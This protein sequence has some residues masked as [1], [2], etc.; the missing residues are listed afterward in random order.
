MSD[1]P[2]ILLRAEEKPLEHRSF[3]PAVIK[4]LVDAGYPISVERSS[5]DPNFKRIFEDSEYEAAGASLIPA[6]SWPEAPAGTLI[7]GLKEIPEEDFPL[8]NDHISFA[9]C[10]K[11]QGGWEKVLSRFPRGGSVLYDLEFLVDS[12]GRRVSAFGFHAGFTGAALG[13]KTLQWQLAHPGEKLPSVGTFTDGRGYYLN[14]EELVNQIREDLASAEK[15]LGRKPTAMV[16][17]ALGRCGRGAVDLFL[18]AGIPEENIT[19]WDIQET[20][21]REGPYE[22]IAQHDIFLN[23]IYLSKPIPPFVNDELLSQPGRKLGVV[24]DVSCDTTNPHNPIPIYSINTTFDDPTVPV[25]VKD[26]QNTSPLSVIS[27][28]H[29]PSMLPRE[30]S[31]AFSEGLKESLLTLN[32]R[33]TSRVWADAEKLFNEKVALLPEE[34]RTKE[35]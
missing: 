20:Q 31:E 9:H 34:L 5:T 11:N 21:A 7:L 25:T 27:I 4:T 26:D 3:S 24:I 30:A 18:K 22:E 2:A 8:K 15:A 32:E 19:R 12:E 35:V 10:Y 6:G 14:E 1:Y 29:L 28:D 33:K 23:A 13:L 16:L 17:G